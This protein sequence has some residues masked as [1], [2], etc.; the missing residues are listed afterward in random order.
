MRFNA[1]IVSRETSKQ[2]RFLSPLVSG[3]IIADL[4][5]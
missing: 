1:T 3:D 5:R 4:A 2:A